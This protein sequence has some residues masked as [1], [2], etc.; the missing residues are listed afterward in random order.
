MRSNGWG[1]IPLAEV[2][3]EPI[4]NG[5]SPVESQAW[6]GVRML[7]LGCLTGEG[8]QPSQLK[9]APSATYGSHS[10][11]L[12]DGDLL[13]SRAN[14]RN[15]VGLAGIYRDV[16][17]PCIY[18]DLMMRLRTSPRYLPEFLELVLRAP[19]IRQ[20]IAIMAQ[21]TSESMVKI[22]G[23]MLGSLLIPDV[24]IDEQRRIVEVVRVVSV[25][26]R[27]IGA[28]IAKLRGMRQGVLFASMAS[29]DG[30]EVQPGWTRTRLKEVVPKVEYG[31]SEA[32][33]RDSQGIPVLR[34]NNLEDGKPEL[35]ELRYC[36]VL[37]PHR[38]E[39]R[40]GDVLF[41]RTNSIDHIG[42]SGMWRSEI[43]RATFAS[44][45]VR[46]NPDPSRLIPE[47][48]VEWLMHPLIRQRV[49]SISTV[50]V[51]Q[52]NVN[53][54]RLCELE[55]DMPAD[56]TEQRRIVDALYACD[57]QIEGERAELAKLRALKTGLVDDLLTGR[58]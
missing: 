35:S 52:V 8:F 39:L 50:A 16:G 22:S 17:G 54:T 36:P 57:E 20:R 13:I 26:E 42:K 29:A 58:V 51:Q 43:P 11:L 6:T 7:G 55:I 21:G 41:N 32:L 9:N 53:P 47:Y 38:L 40:H 23:G 4:R 31:T 46:I 18:P 28:S 25:H 2:L 27:A 1:Q 19:R 33:S 3:A 5:V 10:A 45:L 49:R 30:R 44:Y 34:M 24:P 48:L 14:T 56:P 15:L 12:R 37:V